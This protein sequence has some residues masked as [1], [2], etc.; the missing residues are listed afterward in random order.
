MTVDGLVYVDA[1]DE[2]DIETNEIGKNAA[3]R[4]LGRF[5]HDDVQNACSGR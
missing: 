3:T 2:H 5:G 4:K 1:E